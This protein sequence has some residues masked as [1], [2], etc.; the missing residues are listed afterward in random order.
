LF[1]SNFPFDPLI[2]NTPYLM[3]LAPGGTPS[4]LRRMPQDC[5]DFR[6]QPNGLLTYHD[7][8]S[9]CFM[10]MDSTFTVV[11][12]FKCGNG[13]PTDVHELRLLPDGHA[14]LLGYDPEHVR[15]DSVARGG[16]SAAIVYGLILQELDRSKNVIFQWRSWDH[17][18]ITDAIGVD[19]TGHVVDYVHGNAIEID[20]DGNLLVSSRHLSEVTKINRQTGE[21]IW[22]WG[23]K[24]NQ[25]TFIG[26]SAGFSYQHALRRLPGG[27]WTMFDNGYFHTPQFS[28]A[29]EYALD[30][31][32]K[33]STLVW[34]FRHTPDLFGAA[35]GSVQRMEDGTTL[36][37]WGSTN[38][39]VT[40]VDPLGGTL[41]ELSLPQ[42]VFSYRAFG[43]ITSPLTSIPPLPH[44]FP[45]SPTLEENYPNPFN[46][47]TVIAYTLPLAGHVRLTVHDILGRE[48]AILVDGP[49]PAGRHTVTWNAS[50]VA[51]GP[52]FCRLRSGGVVQVLKMLLLK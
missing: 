27:H 28:R 22:R 19:F 41:L 42:G 4:F 10:A 30:E 14:L 6:Q 31:Q 15:M 1:L 49:Q 20:A 24:N 18:R 44:P 50:N 32:Q 12:S 34:Q 3:I 48:T 33:T 25:F 16:D 39:S 43:S 26:D 36:I 37:G 21:I 47:S 9:G 23:G 46:P 40:L 29:V 35:M 8:A 11:D 5:F 13:Y 2:H 51:S 17:F 38:P 45:R 52:Y 7:Q